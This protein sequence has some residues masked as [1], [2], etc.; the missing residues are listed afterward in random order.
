MS[1]DVFEYRVTYQ[2]SRPYRQTAETLRSDQDGWEHFGGV[3]GIMYVIAMECPEFH[4]GATDVRIE[5]RL[6]KP[7][8][9]VQVTDPAVIDQAVKQAE[10]QR[11]RDDD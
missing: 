11:E 9:T 10:K 8:E 6:V 5:R 2:G 7:W 1:D 4:P 3:E